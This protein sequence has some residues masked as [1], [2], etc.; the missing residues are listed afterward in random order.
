MNAETCHAA[1]K[2]KWVPYYMWITSHRI[3]AGV[4]FLTFPFNNFMKLLTVLATWE[5][6]VLKIHTHTGRS[7]QVKSILI[8]A[9]SFRTKRLSATCFMLVSWPAYS[10]TLEK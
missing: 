7:F 3:N 4:K 9:H 2:I 10:S 1:A 5:Q 8:K 6:V